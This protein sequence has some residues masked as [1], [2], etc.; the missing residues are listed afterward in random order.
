[1]KSLRAIDPFYS[2]AFPY[3]TALATEYR[4]NW[5]ETLYGIC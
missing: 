2:N 3:S 4:K 1:M 5:R